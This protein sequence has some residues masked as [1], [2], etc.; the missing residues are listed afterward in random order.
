MAMCWCDGDQMWRA[1]SEERQATDNQPLGVFYFMPHWKS[2]H[3]PVS[4]WQEIKCAENSSAGNNKLDRPKGDRRES[5]GEGNRIHL[6]P[7][8]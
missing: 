7:A 1:W 4:K 6:L 2:L 5:S 8:C 3:I